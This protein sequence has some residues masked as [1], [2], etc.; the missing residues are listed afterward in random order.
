MEVLKSP[1]KVFFCLFCY[2]YFYDLHVVGGAAAARPPV[3]V[4]GAARGDEVI[5]LT[6]PELQAPGCRAK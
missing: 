2:Y 6:W 5:I 4:P 3:Q 1:H